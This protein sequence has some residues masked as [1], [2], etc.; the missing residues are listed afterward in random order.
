MGREA[1]QPVNTNKNY[2]G[3]P[4][5]GLPLLQHHNLSFLPDDKITDNGYRFYFSLPTFYSLPHWEPRQHRELASLD[6]NVQNTAK[7]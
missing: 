1:E 6:A 7:V 3:S 2:D 4:L 5:A